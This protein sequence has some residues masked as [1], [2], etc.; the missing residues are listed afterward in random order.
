MSLL[1]IMVAARVQY[2]TNSDCRMRDKQKLIEDRA[3]RKCKAEDVDYDNAFEACHFIIG[4]WT[5]GE[6]RG[7]TEGKRKGAR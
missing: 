3:W 2:R 4:G 1:A 6:G 5:S 7:G